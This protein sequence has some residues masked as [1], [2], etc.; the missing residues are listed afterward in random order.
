MKKKRLNEKM[1]GGQRIGLGGM[2]STGPHYPRHDF[3]NP[4]GYSLGGYR[5]DPDSQFSQRISL[6]STLEENEEEQSEENNDMSEEKETLYEYFARIAKLPLNENKEDKQNVEEGHCDI[7]EGHCKTHESSCSMSEK[8]CDES[9]RIA[10]EKELA[11]MTTTASIGGGPATPLG[12][13][14]KGKVPSRNRRKSRM[15]HAKR[16]FGGK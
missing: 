14:A 9:I 15:N 1:G 4:N 6:S 10:E 2:N 5:G 13:D 7:E 8:Q 3:N 12:T 11:E 16:T